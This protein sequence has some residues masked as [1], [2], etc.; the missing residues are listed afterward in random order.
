MEWE[1]ISMIKSVLP[2]IAHTRTLWLDLYLHIWS[3]AMTDCGSVPPHLV[4]LENSRFLAVLGRWLGHGPWGLYR[5][6]RFIGSGAPRRTQPQHIFGRVNVPVVGSAT[7]TGPLTN[8]ERQ[9]LLRRATLRARLTGGRPTV[10]D[11]Y[12]SAIPFCWGVG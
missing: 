2:L 1:L 7:A 8:I 4:S 3:F 12:F 6:T 11:K 9:N 5:S 10:H